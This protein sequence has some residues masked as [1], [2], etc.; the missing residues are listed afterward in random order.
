M[1]SF[2][3]EF[4][5]VTSC[6]SACGVCSSISE[7]DLLGCD[8]NGPETRGENKDHNGK[9]NG[10]LRCDAPRLTVPTPIRMTHG[11]PT[12]QMSVHDGRGR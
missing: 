2:D 8:L 1:R 5:G 12:R 3:R 4:D 10:K 7:P 6:Q 11:M 9:G